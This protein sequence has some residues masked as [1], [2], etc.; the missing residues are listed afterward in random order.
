MA[1]S[2]FLKFQDKNGDGS[3]DVCDDL[4]IAPAPDKCSECLPD[5]A[6]VVPD[7]KN[8][9]R[10]NPFLN[11]RIAKYQIT[12]RTTSTTTG[13]QEGDTEEQALER[14]KEIFQEYED[15]AIRWLLNVFDKS[16]SAASKQKVKDV[17]EHTEFYL[18]ARPFSKLRLLYSVDCETLAN[19]GPAEEEDTSD[20]ESPQAVTYSAADLRIKIGK[21]NKGLGLYNRY[22]CMAKFVEGVGLFYL[23]GDKANAI[24]DLQKY[25]LHFKRVSDVSMIRGLF[26][27]L[28]RFLNTKKLN[29]P[30]SGAMGGIHKDRVRNME[31]HFSQEYKLEKLLV[32]TEDCGTVPKIYGPEK[33]KPLNSTQSWKDSTAVAYFAKLDEMIDDL[34]AREPMQW[35]EFVK[36]HT[37]PEIYSTINAGYTN[38]DPANTIGSCIADN[39]ANEAKQLG[40]DIFNEAFSLGNAIAKRF[41]DNV[42]VSDEERAKERQRMGTDMPK[43]PRYEGGWIQK[44]KDY[45]YL[46]EE[47]GKEYADQW[48][49]DVDTQLQDERGEFRANIVSVASVQSFEQLQ[50][51]DPVVSEMCINALMFFAA[52]GLNLRVMWDETLGALKWCGLFGLMTKTV[53]CLF[54]G[55]TLEEALAGIVESA[56]NSMNVTNFGKLFVGLPPEKQAEL[57]ALVRKNLQEG[58]IFKEGS[59]N[60]EISDIVAE[61]NA[62]STI[63]KPWQEEQSEESDNTSISQASNSVASGNAQEEASGYEGSGAPRTLAKQLDGSSGNQLKSTVVMQAY[64]KALLELYTD[65]LLSLVDQLNRFP[66]APLV[67]QTLALM[68]CP[69]DPLFNP[70][71]MDFIKSVDLPLCRNQSR[72]SLPYLQLP[73]FR[74]WW[75]MIT[76]GL[77]QEVMDALWA[78]YKKILEKLFYKLC[79]LLG[80]AV[81]KALEVVGDAV[82][83]AFSQNTFGELVRETICGEEID[84]EQLENTIIDM[85]SSLGMGA[86]A[87]ADTERTMAFFQDASS[88]NTRREWAT[89]FVGEASPQSLQIIQYLIEDEY[90]EFRGVFPNTDSVGS[91]FEAIGNLMPT[92]EKR[93]LQELANGLSPDEQIPAN[94]SLC[95]TPLQVEEWCQM[96][97]D[98]LA[99]RATSQQVEEM[100]LAG[101]QQGVSDI[102]DF[103]N[104]LNDPANLVDMPPLI[105]APGCD[106]GIAPFETQDMV[107]TARGLIEGDFEMLQSA[108]SEDMVG[109][110]P[111]EKRWGMINM[112]LSD[113][114]ANPLTVHNRK[115]FFQRRYVDFTMDGG[116]FSAGST[117]ADEEF[118]NI[119]WTFRQQGAYPNKV[120]Q[121]LQTYMLESI[122]TAFYST[123]DQLDEEV[124]VQ[125]LNLILKQDLTITDLISVPDLGYNVRINPDFENNE[126]QLIKE[127]R[128]KTPDATLRYE[129]NNKGEGEDT[130]Y[131]KGYEVELYIADLEKVDGS[132]RNVRGS[133]ARIAIYDLMNMDLKGRGTEFLASIA[134]PDSRDKLIDTIKSKTS[135]DSE[136]EMKDF[137]YEFIS[138]DEDVFENVDISQY[139]TFA[140]SFDS[141]NSYPPPVVLLNELM[142]TAGPGV[143]AVKSFCDGF[144]TTALTSIIADVANNSDAYD[145]GAV[146]DD[147]TYSDVEYVVDAGQTS[148][149]AGTPY[150][151]AK[152]PTDDGTG[153]RKIKNADQILGVSRMQLTDPDNNRVFYLDPSQYGG[154]Y[155]NPPFY[156]KP[157]KNTG[158]LGLIDVLFPEM[159]ACKPRYTNLVDFEDIQAQVDEVYPTI[160]QDERLSGNPDCAVEL[161][162]NRILERQSV[163]AI[164]G[165]VKAA[166]RIYVS[167]GMIKSLATFTQFYPKFTSNFS[168]LYA[169]YI[170]EVME[171]DF[172]DSQGAFWEAFSTFKDDEFWYAFLEQS[173]QMY[174]RLI[175]SGNIENPP[176]EILNILSELNDLQEEMYEGYPYR[177]DQ[178]EALASKETRRLFLNRYRE[179]I[180]FYALVQTQEKAKRVLKELV[181]EE[182]NVMGE[183]I[184]SNL[185]IIGMSPAVYDMNYYFL[186]TFTQGSSLDM[187][188]EIT[189]EVEGVPTEEVDEQYTAGGELYVVEARGETSLSDG[190]EY[191]GYYHVHRAEDGALIWMA[192]EFHIEGT[193]NIG[194]DA[195]AESSDTSVVEY[196]AGEQ[197]ILAPF[198]NKIIV[199]IGD[200]AE[201]GFEAD[202][203]STAQ[204]FVIEKYISINGVKYSPT[205][206]LTQIK[207]N[208]PDLNISEVYPGDMKIVTDADGNEV[209][210]EGS[211][212]VRYGLQLSMV[213]GGSQTELTT[214]EV[215]ALDLPI[216]QINPFAGD[217]KM[218]FCL[219]LQLVEDERFKLLTQYIFP[220]NKLTATTAIYN[221]MG[222]LSSINQTIVEGG[223]QAFVSS[224]PAEHPGMRIDSFEEVETADGS[225]TLSPQT[226]GT[227]GWAA[228]IV[229]GAGTPFGAV[230]IFNLKY[231]FWD[232]ELLRNTRSTLKRMFKTHYNMRDF[233]DDDGMPTPGEVLINNLRS[234]LKPAP[235]RSLLP[236]WQARLRR[237]NPFNKD[238]D[239]CD[240]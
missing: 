170:V 113:T 152:V 55:L 101:R 239:L 28:D 61:I 73:E 17:I 120:A 100:C 128:K 98:I 53:A 20:Q 227:D 160:P 40:Q 51:D 186:E 216:V 129:D 108:F 44:R 27:S 75:A 102:I 93:K 26:S 41:H 34:E 166:I 135:N 230:G 205:D 49:E 46:V 223:A 229:R 12:F 45:K 33:L 68:D 78:A 218:L 15:E 199:P 91:F 187:N 4:P 213:Y 209:G 167:V 29:I 74:G 184:V 154:N 16:T 125:D 72:I 234:F 52:P 112:I 92:G 188:K 156:I 132:W 37:Y 19:L 185:G 153:E 194:G 58:N 226:A 96:R 149:P 171:K 116:T 111:G 232:Q 47:Q 11:E 35:L 39:L 141:Y 43:Y 169:S 94:A 193:F 228:P 32:Y 183:K 22:Y 82:E 24:F 122:N 77:L 14:L 126:Y 97:K 225:V 143:Y 21:V 62:G 70:N 204:P 165:I 117:T 90:Q 1:E 50:S 178:L 191:I 211:L 30:G 118:G 231:D 119:P 127:P 196:T 121:W 57:D 215:D 233:N 162:Y 212:G 189:E 161:P 138:F 89:L 148:A 236:W 164:Q 200:V 38:T 7:W 176:Q 36:K 174:G 220:L 137:K 198:A 106:N 67:F 208:D 103:G 177:Q 86:A 224:D 202:K 139:P 83:A 210:I 173:V 217:S 240:K 9:F 190:D 107:A 124:F 159:S 10:H 157:S 146:F 180:K 64:V 18:D 136:K 214:V 131:D 31:F 2:K 60:Q 182:L 65:D 84:D 235:G 195:S 158:W 115:S 150:A 42:C 123:N 221:D 87:L 145:Y 151:E 179:D 23:E 130:G 48:K 181:L 66:G 99:G 140:A 71:W 8:R 59:Y 142:G 134:D 197:S 133:N 172:K 95:A 237:T 219:I 238:G 76:N 79:E 206:A 63:S 85:A 207:A 105:S 3:L 114:M 104:I 192:G 163:A 81:C 222:F 144:M 201:F 69:R 109:N 168:S 56:L 25:G 80:G 5:P 155:M 175:D 110:G 13:V 6:F 147:L 203:S 88:T 54:K